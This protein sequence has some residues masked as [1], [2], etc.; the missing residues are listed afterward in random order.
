[1]AAVWIERQ[2]VGK[3]DDSDVSCFICRRSFLVLCLEV[4]GT[5]N[6]NPLL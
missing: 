2:G 5:G 6:G 1:M 3:S 4:F